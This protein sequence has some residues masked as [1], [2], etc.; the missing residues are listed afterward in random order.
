MRLLV[1]SCR[2]IGTGIDCVCACLFVRVVRARAR[3]GRFVA[4][5]SLLCA[6]FCSAPAAG[7]GGGEDGKVTEVKAKAKAATKAPGVSSAV[8]AT[9]GAAKVRRARLVQ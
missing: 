5:P 6:F 3:G 8:A 4:P 7:G 2:A 1:P 9:A